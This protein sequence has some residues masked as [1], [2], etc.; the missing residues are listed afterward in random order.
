MARVSRKLGHRADLCSS[1]VEDDNIN[2]MFLVSLVEPIR[3]PTTSRPSM[4]GTVMIGLLFILAS[5]QGLTLVNFSVQ[6][7]RFLLDRGCIQGLSRGLSGGV[8]G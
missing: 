5:S 8:S 1:D 3:G 4:A 2:M 7:E 6:R